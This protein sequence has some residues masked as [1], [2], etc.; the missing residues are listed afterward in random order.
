MPL[1]LTLRRNLSASPLL[2]NG[3]ALRGIVDA[4]ETEA[5]AVKI[6]WRWEDEPAMEPQYL[7]TGVAG[8]DLVVPFDL[9]GR[10]I[11]LFLVSKTAA[12]RGSVQDIKEAEQTVYTTPAL[13]LAVDTKTSAYT[14]TD[15]DDLV[16][17]D[18]TGGAVTIT[19]HAAATAKQKPYNFKKIDSSANAMTIDGNASE[20]I[21]GA[22]TKSTTIQ[23][24]NF[25][26]VP[27]NTTGAWSIV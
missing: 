16:L 20:T 17:V 2:P 4:G 19:L 7:G 26:L 5:V 25:T 13:R 27:N 3:L 23:Y 1:E 12:N 9:N 22:T 21:D 18:C 6:Y 15:D 11:R 10:E 24:T 8:H 14:L